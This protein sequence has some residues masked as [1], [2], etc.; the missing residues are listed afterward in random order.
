MCEF[1][2]VSSE[3]PCSDVLCPWPWKIWQLPNIGI[4]CIMPLYVEVVIG[5]K[6]GGLSEEIKFTYSG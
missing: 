6:F 5:L 1:K 4:H 2:H 3:L